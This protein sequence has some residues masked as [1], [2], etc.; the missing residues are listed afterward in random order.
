MKSAYLFFVSIILMVAITASADDYFDQITVFSDGK[1][2]RFTQMP[3]KVYITPLQG[4]E[5][6][7][8]DVRYAMQEWQVASDGKIQFQEQ[9]ELSDDVDIRV[10]WRRDGLTQVTDTKLGKTEL[11]RL[12]ATDLEVEIILSL[13]EQGVAGTLSH[14]KMR[15]ACLHEFGHALGLWGHSPDSNDV[16]FFAATAQHPTA[17]DRAT[18]LRVYETPVNKDQHDI[19][20]GVLKKQLDANPKHPRTH[21]LLGAVYFDQ[22]DMEAAIASFKTCLELDGAGVK[23]LHQQAREKLLQAYQQSGQGVEAL[24][25]LENTLDSEASA[26]GYNTV[27]VMYYKNQEVD[28]AIEAF[29]KAIQINPRYQPAKNNLYHLY[30]DQ[31]TNALKAETYVQAVT[32]FS[33][34]MDLNATDATLYSLMGETYAKSGDFSTAIGHYRKAL[35]LNPGDAEAIKNLAWGYNNLGVEL[36]RGQHW[37]EAINSY[38]QALQ[39]MPDSDIRVNLVGAYWKRANAYRET[40]NVNNAI[41]A[42]DKLLEF[43]SDS[44]DAHS[45]LGDLY[46]KKGEYPQ[47]INEFHAALESA[48]DDTQVRRNLVA[49]YHQYGQILERQKRYREAIDQLQRGLVLEPEHIN[50]RLSLAYVHQN[51]NNFDA[52]KIAFE[53]I[54]E[55]DADNSQAKKELINLH[56][57]SGN[58]LLNRK[59]YTAA[60]KEFEGITKSARNAGIYNTI[61]YLYLMK[62]QPLKALPAFDAALAD[63]AMDDVAYQNLLSIESQFDRQFDKINDS[64]AKR[65]KD[66]E[67]VGVEQ[68]EVA[69]TGIEDSDEMRAIKSKL[70]RVRSSLVNCLIG[71][72]EHLKAKAKY[73]AALE[74]APTDS[75]TKAI[76]IDTGIFLA[77]EFQK[78]KWPK[79]MKEV[80]GWIQEHDSENPMARKLLKEAER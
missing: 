31:G 60:L 33:L 3:I 13:R 39:L 68:S 6:Y 30:L 53:K 11:I 5:A 41:E 72:K 16:L 42:Y 65:I 8:A 49:V 51:T 38:H 22:E 2:T 17:Q 37:Q 23:S 25:L 69:D 12:S 64:E 58:Y 45:L 35:Q 54:L 4:T 43:D 40:G 1:I 7:L 74:L 57:R 70:V 73:R 27:G 14:E 24:N 71:R 77:Q 80:I 32:Y 47:A 50:L 26:E 48:P 55:I 20:I 67:S 21:Y 76:L 78:K 75:E 36:S 34:S 15:T 10:S 52:A 56:I 44:V 18:L 61:G 28:K 29:K 66:S 63:Q 19:A 62:K 9:A 79:N 59:Q 46:L